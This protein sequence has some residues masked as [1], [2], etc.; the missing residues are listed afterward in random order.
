M[1]RVRERKVAPL[2][3][4]RSLEKEQK[5]PCDPFGLDTIFTDIRK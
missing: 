1:H 4:M 5:G 2:T 3:L